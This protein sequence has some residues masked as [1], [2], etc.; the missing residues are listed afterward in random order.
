[1]TEEEPKTEQQPPV[2]HR[3]IRSYVLRE[4]RLTA[5]QK[6]AFEELWPQF[7]IEYQAALLDLPAIFGNSNPVMLEIGFGNGV[8][9]AQ[10]AA[11][12][13]DNNYLGIEVHSPG[14]GHLL[15]KI[16]ELGLSNLRVMRHDAV[17]V[18]QHCIADASLQGTFL[19]FPDPW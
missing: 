16:E 5:G 13:P 14:V 4:G 10:M 8:S 11:A 17:E 19:F 9:L 7:G 2:H 1:M 6:R 3:R 12:N 15:M 18:L